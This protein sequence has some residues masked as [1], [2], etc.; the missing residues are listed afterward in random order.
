M[1]AVADQSDM[2]ADIRYYG[3]QIQVLDSCF[4]AS[5][6]HHHQSRVP[7]RDAGSAAHQKDPI[8]FIAN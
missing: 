1:I 4:R 3:R 5:K 8:R 7:M 6:T 2:L